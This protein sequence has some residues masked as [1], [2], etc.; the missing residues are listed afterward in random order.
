MEYGKF[1]RLE[2]IYELGLTDENSKK[3]LASYSYNAVGTLEKETYYDKGLT[4]YSK[5]I[6]NDIYGRI[7]RIDYK[8][9]QEKGLYKEELHYLAP[10]LN[11][12]SGITHTWSGNTLQELTV[13]ESFGYDDLGRLTTFE[14]D[15]DGMSYGTYGYDVLGRLTL[16]ADMY[17]AM[18]FGYEDGSYQPVSVHENN[19]E[20]PRALEYDASGNMWLDGNTRTAYRTNAN[21]QM[22]RVAFYKGGF[23]E[24]LSADN[25]GDGNGVRQILYGYD[26]GGARIWERSANFQEGDYGKITI[27]G[28]GSF[29]K[30][31]GATG[32]TLER[33]DL[34]AG[35]YRIGA[36]GSAMFPLTDAQGNI[37]GY[38]DRT[39]LRSKYAYYPFGSVVTMD[40]E[41]SS[42]DN[43]RWQS[44]EYEGEYGKYYFGARYYDPS[45]GLWTSPDPA[46][47][48]QNPY[49]YGGDPVNFVDPTGMWSVGIG[50][51]F[52][53]DSEHGWQVGFG[54]AFSVSGGLPGFNNSYTWNQDGSNSFNFGGE[55]SVWLGV[56]DLGYGLSYSW[57]TYSGSVLSARGGMCVGKEG[58]ACSG[59]EAGGALSWN[60]SGSFMGATAYIGAYA[61]VFG[62]L[63][64]VSNGYEEGFLGMEGRGLYAGATVAGLH[65]EVSERDGDSW[66]FEERLF[67][68]IGNN[69]NDIAE[70]GTT[71]SIIKWELWIPSL[72]RF[73]HLTFGSGYD[74]SNDGLGKALADEV[75]PLLKSSSNEDDWK[76]AEKIRN[77]PNNLTYAEFQKLNQF[78]LANGFERVERLN[79]HSDGFKKATYRK[80]GSIAYGNIE[81]M[82]SK[83]ENRAYSSYNYG[84]NFISHI[85]IDY[86]GWKGRGY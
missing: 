23:P 5:E 85:L 25:V 53:W 65:A 61:E 48:F 16:K 26:E 21:G 52:G 11:R 69:S 79:N 59:M 55:G 46:G 86:F 77:N 66:G 71:E 4:V 24:G 57:N 30:D 56:L 39:S 12:L 44:K 67:F 19:Y 49:T 73:G 17:R 20:I 14:T 31:R 78:L 36:D 60:R 54:S 80:A 22:I 64:R 7:T 83:N 45:L 74:V 6:D 72:G 34:A 33:L 42:A 62:G 50:M 18:K 68:G 38:A 35:G 75:V 15:M 47:Q 82:Y 63:A 32:Y 43:R 8:N 37:R 3:A 2:K 10:A 51:V 41:E 84:N 27:P 76:L 13:E 28:L 40:A 29:M 81:L 58:V 70:D 1:D 9:A